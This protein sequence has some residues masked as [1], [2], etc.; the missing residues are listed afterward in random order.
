MTRLIVV[1]ALFAL[2]FQA[3]CSGPPCLEE[4]QQD[5]VPVEGAWA[6]SL[7]QP[8][9]E[10]ACEGVDIQALIRDELRAGLGGAGDGMVHLDLGGVHLEGQV[11][12]EQLYAE[13]WSEA[14]FIREQVEGQRL[15]MGVVMDAWLD[16]PSVMDGELLLVVE[17]PR[18]ACEVT[19]WFHGEPLPQ[20]EGEG[21]PMLCDR[22]VPEDPSAPVQAP[23]D[24]GGTT[25]G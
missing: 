14:G 1:V 24:G 18:G 23:E 6:L 15:P 19:A 12:G 20:G 8:T 22:P 2:I 16:S 4:V 3:D 10:G 21:E 17:A 7:E 11:R 25:C 5:V 13:G 9:L